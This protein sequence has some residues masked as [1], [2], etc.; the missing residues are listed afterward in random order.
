MMVVILGLVV[1]DVVVLVCSMAIPAARFQA[2]LVPDKEFPP[3]RDV[4]LIIIKGT[5]RLRTCLLVFTVHWDTL[6]LL[7]QFTRTPLVY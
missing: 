7:T 6:S 1:V 2:Q 5:I 3:Y 4:S